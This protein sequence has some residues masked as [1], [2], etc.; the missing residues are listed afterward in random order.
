MASFNSTD[1]SARPELPPAETAGGGGRRG[2]SMNARA[3]QSADPDTWPIV[4]RVVAPAAGGYNHDLTFIETDDERE[5]RK[6]FA[7]LRRAGY[8]VRLERVSC[9]PLPAGAEANLAALRAHSPQNVGD[10]AREVLG[11]WEARGAA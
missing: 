10:Q 8:P 9:G 2:C 3:T 4:W 1:S 5:A 11:Y 7:G 6:R